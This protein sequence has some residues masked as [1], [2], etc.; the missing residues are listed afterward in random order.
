MTVLKMIAGVIAVM[1]VLDLIRRTRRIRRLIDQHN[2]H[3]I[4]SEAKDFYLRSKNVWKERTDMTN[5]LE[6]LFNKIGRNPQGLI[7]SAPPTVEKVVKES[8]TMLGGGAATIMQIAHPFVAEGVYFHSNVRND[9][10]ERFYGT[11]KFVFAMM[12]GSWDQLVKASK[13]VWALHSRVKGTI[14]SNDGGE[15]FPQG[16][17][18]AASNQAAL[19]YV[20]TNLGDM[21]I[22]SYEIFM[23][24][25][26]TIEEK[27]LHLRYGRDLAHCFGCSPED[28]YPSESYELFMSYNAY[29]WSIIQP[30]AQGRE[31]IGHLVRSP[32]VPD[33][34]M[35]WLVWTMV[36]DV[37]RAKYGVEISETQQWIACATAAL[38]SQIYQLIPRQF[39][40]YTKYVEATLRK[41][42]KDP[43]SDMPFINKVAN[44]CARTYLWLALDFLNK[45]QN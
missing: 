10:K 24:E 14:S 33:G 2:S 3:K 28:M 8:V 12:F 20:L 41:E 31:L 5:H 25:D 45:I 29:M 40:I 22:F 18:Y 19:L 11:F 44:L 42:G 39:R 32:A 17:S 1:G 4:T 35:R 9:P 16:T 27:N 38:I 26:L 7:A 23:D 30:T 36:P 34:P 15:E 43:E 6:I 21:A 37:L 13:T